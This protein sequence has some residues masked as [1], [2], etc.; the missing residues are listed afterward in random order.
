MSFSPQ[1]VSTSVLRTLHRIHRQLTDLRERLERGPKQVR[2]AEASVQQQ[3]NNLA[4]VD[5][6][7]KAIRMAA[8]AKQGELRASEEKVRELESQ[9]K[10]ASSNREYQI[11]KDQIAAKKVTNSLLDDEILERWDK[12]DQF[13]QKIVQAQA[14]VARAR[15]KVDAVRSEVQK[16]EPL[17]RGDI[18]RLEAEL[19]QCEA[20]L[21]ATVRELYNRVVRHRGEDALAAVENEYCS[22]C[23]QHVPLNVCAE[24][25]LSHPQFCKTCGRLLY[26]PEDATAEKQAKPTT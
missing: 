18:Q 23:H 25:K 12:L 7:S 15:E 20:A 22:G 26:I 16:N 6:E 3:E 19:K 21:P 4:A 5:A 14:A 17:I 11:L 24:I 10:T 13:K 2:A 1:N 8:D 9:L